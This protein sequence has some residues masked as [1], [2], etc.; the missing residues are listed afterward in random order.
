MSFG[1]ANTMRPAYGLS[2]AAP[3]RVWHAM[4]WVCGAACAWLGSSGITQGKNTASP[5]T[6]ARTG[7]SSQIA[8]SPRKR[9]VSVSA[10][11]SS[12]TASVAA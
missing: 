7:T 11:G 8:R 6:V 5:T 4:S 10:T 9:V 3:A 1:S 2:S 12:A